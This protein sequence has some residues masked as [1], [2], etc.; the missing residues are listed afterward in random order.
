[1]EIG[2]KL[3][4]LGVF[5]LFLFAA[6]SAL[7]AL[8][9]LLQDSAVLDRAYIPALMLSNG[10]NQA[11]A[12][13][14]QDAYL[15]AWEAFAAKQRNVKPANPAWAKMF[16]NIDKANVDARAALVAGRLADAH[17][18][19]EDVRHELWRQR[20][21]MGLDYQPDRLTAF[22]ETMEDLIASTPGKEPASIGSPQIA[23]M[24]DQLGKARTQWQ[25]VKSARWEPTDYGLEG[26]RL[27]S[28]L[29]A[30]AAEDKALDE[31]TAALDAGDA[32][33]IAKAAPAIKP[34][35]AKAYGAFGVFPQ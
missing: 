17:M 20:Q 10:K 24:K 21:A 34:P 6:G 29:A 25:A 28:Y 15:I 16:E 31:F 27:E 9:A 33:R 5:A 35:F 14:A 11:K 30:V 23:V 7:A 1:M 19:Q 13:A 12:L 4:Q 22:H 8:P 32:A 18:V 2:M 3:R 26:A